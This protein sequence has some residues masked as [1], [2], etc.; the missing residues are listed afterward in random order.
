M[1]FGR[2]IFSP[3]AEM[4]VM[5]E[6]VCVCVCQVNEIVERRVFLDR[7]VVEDWHPRFNYINGWPILLLSFELISEV[8]ITSLCVWERVRE[9]H[10]EQE[11]GVHIFNWSWSV[12]FLPFALIAL[13]SLA[14]E[15]WVYFAR[16]TC[17]LLQ[18]YALQQFSKGWKRSDLER[19]TSSNIDF[20]FVWT[21]LIS[22]AAFTGSK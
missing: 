15:I 13:Y 14:R 1:T 5:N 3:T 21:K 17:I 20:M 16:F 6:F 19:F 12:F 7:I 11:K 18:S 2:A 8:T 4:T 9:N 10:Q 22:S